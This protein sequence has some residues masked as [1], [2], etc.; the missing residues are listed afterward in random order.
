MTDYKHES[1]AK[2]D[3]LFHKHR[4][5]LG[6]D[7]GMGMGM[8]WKA[9]SPTIP[10]I[11]IGLDNDE[12]MLGKI[13]TFIRMISDAFEEDIDKLMQGSIEESAEGE[14]SDS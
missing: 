3:E 10:E 1:I 2:L 13:A 9:I 6:K 5:E 14:E 7:A 12:D 4:E 8:M 11:L